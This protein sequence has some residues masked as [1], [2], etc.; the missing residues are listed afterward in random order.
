[1][2]SISVMILFSVFF[3]FLSFG[4]ELPENQKQSDKSKFLTADEFKNAFSKP[5][6][7]NQLDS[8]IKKINEKLPYEIDTITAS[9]F[10]NKEY[11]NIET[12]SNTLAASIPQKYKYFWLPHWQFKGKG[13]VMLPGAD[14]STD[15]SL[16]AILETVPHEND[17]YGTMVVLINTYNWT[18][19]RIHYYNNKLLTK[20][21]FRPE[22]NQL[23]VWEKSQ[24]NKI[25]KKIHLI[26]IK[27][28]NIVSS[29]RDINKTLSGIALD[30]AGNKVYLK[31]VNKAKTIYIFDL[32]NL[33]KKPSKR[34][35]FEE[36]GYIAVSKNS[37]LFAGKE[38]LVEYKLDS[39]QKI[40]EIENKSK[41]IP[42]SIIFL[43]SN[44]KLAFSS[45]MHPMTISIGN[46]SKQ[47]STSAGQV[48]FYRQDIDLLAFEEYKNRQITFFSMSDLESTAK[49]I[50]RKIKPKTKA[51]ALFLSYLPHMERYIVLDKKGNLCLYHKPGKKWRKKILFSAK[52]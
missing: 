38:K 9:G 29:S 22:S 20:V 39:N 46:K 2:K 19:L 48:I 5:K 28:G 25:H 37:L 42:E 50:P 15:R 41:I 30:M 44:N 36:E 12:P 33:T 49:L 23:L 32:E 34:K 52:K 3:Q 47:L 35:C 7:K 11:K 10:A 14:I 6:Y 21:F 13:K 27:S 43:G 51:G 1:M 26:N 8:G 24:N 18:I 16:L 4:Q 40:F 45:Y 31:T 17:D